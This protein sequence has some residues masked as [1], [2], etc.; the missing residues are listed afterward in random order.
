MVNW[1]YAEVW[2]NNMLKKMKNN[3]TSAHTGTQTCTDTHSAAQARS[4]ANIDCP[5]RPKHPQSPPE[6]TRVHAQSYNTAQVRAH[7]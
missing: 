2:S 1:C 5:G 3:K 7:A 4:Q 6:R